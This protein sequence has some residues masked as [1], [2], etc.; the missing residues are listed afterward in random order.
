MSVERERVLKGRILEHS[1][2][3]VAGC[4]VEMVAGPVED[5]LVCLE[6][7][8]VFGDDAEG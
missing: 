1:D 6:D 4:R 8:L 3:A 7:L 5:A 2:A